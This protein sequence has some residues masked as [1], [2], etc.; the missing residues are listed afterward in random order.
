MSRFNP[1]VAETM[2]KV[3]ACTAGEFWQS[4]RSRQPQRQFVKWQNFFRAESFAGKDSH[5]QL[6]GQRK[7]SLAHKA[8]PQVPQNALYYRLYFDL[9]AAFCRGPNSLQ[10]FGI[11]TFSSKFKVL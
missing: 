6:V 9:K 5:F 7:M 2:A 1:K 10:L 3:L 4:G 8:L 11:L